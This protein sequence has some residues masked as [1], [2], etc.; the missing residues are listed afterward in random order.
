MASVVPSQILTHLGRHLAKQI[1]VYMNWL[2]N[3]VQGFY[4]YVA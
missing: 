1:D 2:H 4:S 3:T